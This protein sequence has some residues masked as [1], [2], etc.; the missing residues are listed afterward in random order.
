MR[1]Y[2]TFVLVGILCLMIVSCTKA[3]P[4][5]PEPVVE[6]EASVFLQP[7]SSSANVGNEFA[8]E[9]R[10][11]DVNALFG[12]QFDINYDPQILEVKE[13]K[14]GS[15]LNNEA[16]TQTFCMNPNLGTPGLIKNV[17]CTKL[18]EGSA[19]GSGL[20][21]TITFKA[22]AAGQSDITFSNFKLAD[23]KGVEI[24]ATSS[25]GKADVN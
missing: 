3:P 23:S 20:L 16:T 1:K 4:A 22:L 11:K 6:K 14:E 8:V 10:I 5:S 25:N 19:S 9:V 13:V 15:L 12:F 7:A 2:L 21:E 17:I 18:G 24:K